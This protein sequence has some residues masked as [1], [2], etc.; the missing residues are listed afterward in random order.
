MQT[1][2]LRPSTSNYQVSLFAVSLFVAS[3]WCTSS[4]V[5]RFTSL[6]G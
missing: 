1:A 3:D 6:F 2:L 5:M 4:R